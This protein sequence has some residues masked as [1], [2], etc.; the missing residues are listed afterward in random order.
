LATTFADEY[1]RLRVPF[2]K[3]VEEALGSATK[4]DVTGFT[5]DFNEALADFSAV[6]KAGWIM[7]VAKGDWSAEYKED[8]KAVEQLIKRKTEL[9]SG[10][11]F[12]VIVEGALS[13]AGRKNISGAVIEGLSKL[14]IKASLCDGCERKAKHPYTIRVTGNE[15]CNSGPLGYVCALRVTATVEQGK[16]GTTIFKMKLSDEKGYVGLHPSDENR[17]RERLY[18]NMDKSRLFN[19]IEEGLKNRFPL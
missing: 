2:K 19:L 15:S 13:D 10:L 11:G 1:A 5:V 4:G 16:G 14:G 12:Q 18:E 6:E 9:K 7:K 17:A 3:R 8:T